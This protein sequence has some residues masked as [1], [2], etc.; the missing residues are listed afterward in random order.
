[1]RVA[2]FPKD[3][4]HDY[5]PETTAYRARRPVFVIQFRRDDSGWAGAQATI[6]H[7]GNVKG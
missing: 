6:E 5:R 2:S 1:M 7:R 4:T 3:R